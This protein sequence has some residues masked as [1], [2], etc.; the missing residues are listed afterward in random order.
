MKI[1][2]LRHLLLQLCWSDVVPG[3]PVS[4]SGDGIDVLLDNLLSSRQSVAAAHA[5]PN[6]LRDYLISG[7]CQPQ[8]PHFVT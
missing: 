8:C 6:T 7:L 1:R 5:V 4:F 2:L 3:T